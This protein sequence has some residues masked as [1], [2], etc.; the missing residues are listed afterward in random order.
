[1][2][3]VD[4]VLR[5]IGDAAEISEA[6]AD[7]RRATADLDAELALAAELVASEL[8]T[9]A[10]LHGGGRGRLRVTHTASGGLRIGVA[11]IER[12]APIVGVSNESSM[13]G[14]GLAMIGRL[15]SAWGVT[16]LAE[17][18]EVWAEVQPGS[19][20]DVS[21]DDLLDAWDDGDLGAWGDVPAPTRYTVSL[22]EVPTSLLIRAKSHVDNLVREFALASAGA[23]SGTTESVPPNLAELIHTV[24]HNFVDARDAIKRQAVE[25][26]NSG[27]DHT[28][29][30]LQLPAGAADAG[31]AY[32]SAL[33]E[34][35]RYCRAERLL[36][37]ET[38]PEHR[39]FRQWYVGELVRQLRAASAGEHLPPAMTFE[40]RLVAE[41]ASVALAHRRAERAARLYDV[42][43]ALADTATPSDVARVVLEQ[44]CADLGASGVAVL[45]PG[46]GDHLAVVGSVGYEEGVL[47]QLRHEARDADLPAAFALRTGEPVWIESRDDLRQ[48]FPGLHDFEPGTVSICAVPFEVG[49]RR[50]GVIRL[51]FSE[52][53]LFG[54]DE[55]RFLS[56]LGAQCAQA[57]E[58]TLLEQSRD[59]LRRGAFSGA[60]AVASLEELFEALPAL[61]AYLEGP[62]HVFRYVNRSYQEA[63]PGRTLIG[64]TVAEA[65]PEATDFGF[66]VVADRVWATGQAITGRE[67]VVRIPTA[68][69]QLLDRFA[70]FT[71][72][73][74]RRGDG[75][76]EGVLVHAVDVTD[77]VRARRAL[78]AAADEI[79]QLEM[80]AQ[81]NRFRQAVDGMLDPAMMCRPVRDDAGE[82][83][84]LRVEYA[85][86]AADPG[87]GTG[88]SSVERVLSELWDGIREAGLLAQYVAVAAT[89]EPMVLDDYEYPGGGVFDIRATRVGDA[90]FIVYRD[91]T[92]RAE[93]EAEVEHHRE[94]L[95]EAQRIARMG[96]WVWDQAGD[97]VRWSDEF[98]EIC[99][100]DP[101][102]DRPSREKFL[103]LL[104]E[105]A[106]DDL[107]AAIS[108]AAEAGARF[109]LEVRIRRPDGEERVL[110]V[111]GEASGDTSGSGG[112][113]ATTRGTVQDVTEQ[114]RVE[115]ALRRS[116][117]RRQEEHDAVQ[118][119]QA[120]ILPSE[121]PAIPGASVVARYVAA[122]ENVAV[123]GDFYDVF[124]L[125]DERVL[126]TVGDVAGKG[127]QAAE[128]VGQLRNGL[129][130]AAV[131]DA[132]P[133]AMV[134]SLNALV[135][136]GFKAPFATAV[137]AVYH[138]AEGRLEW[139]S[140]GHLPLVVR[141]SS[142]QAELVGVDPTH[143]PIGVSGE[144]LAGPSALTLDAG[145]AVLLFT[146]GLIE[147]RG[148]DLGDSLDA[149]VAAVAE[150]PVDPAGLVGSVLGRSV[151]SG[152]RQDDVCLLALSRD[153]PA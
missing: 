7:V 69:G 148:E 35:D 60:D 4:A 61:V 83:V 77:D 103:S 76:I 126:L 130:M 151:G 38:P 138:P 110:I 67:V 57:I 58:R 147:R 33:D 3:P 49:G 113:P 146:D 100:F 10:I 73:P 45:L 145:D 9:N 90:V 42:S 98:Y 78:E 46:D 108:S 88:R 59:E 8:M 55:R 48:R 36:T 14:R 82:V 51:S 32:L 116:E 114:R 34:V 101:A 150:G 13:T 86:A 93:R 11:D 12:R 141:R 66:A 50:V 99:G 43:V 27:R 15:S 118:I 19:S 152:V 129:R 64:R 96:S 26:Y 41:V 16:P 137:V 104:D 109:Q 105:R 133:M 44:G 106:V 91:V 144:Q 22:G 79:R 125:D 131:L 89:G 139:A 53:R 153:A 63:L 124:V 18:K 28:H 94:A 81:E 143:P 21:G 23:S 136:R 122:S 92:G 62:Q 127:V 39:L 132:D 117:E 85:N 29:L 87:A 54:E 142:G 111:T 135:G 1:M 80:E 65:L 74:I 68:D 149:L 37:L 24:E 30:E 20:L 123:G 121:L 97:D 52:P 120:A 25:A 72:Q 40:E 115:Q 6:R 17:G 134:A 31:E 107:R 140:A 56:A 71:F 119:L 112:G 2:N 70:D 102:T 47:D 84:D 95:A 128:A 5:D 75:A